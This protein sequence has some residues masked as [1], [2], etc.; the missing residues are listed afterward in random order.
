[1]P[2]FQFLQFG[3]FGKHGYTVGEISCIMY[4]SHY[5]FRHFLAMSV[6]PLMIE[7]IVR[8]CYCAKRLSEGYSITDAMPFELSLAEHKP[9]LRTMLFGAH[10]VSTAANAGKVA[11]LQNPLAINY[12]QWMAFFGY[13]SVPR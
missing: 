10:L 8:L 2:L 13:F 11:L 1:M 4:R 6:A 9:K 3:S 12:S 7:I 5:D